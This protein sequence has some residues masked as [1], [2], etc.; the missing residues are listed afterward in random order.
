MRAK[1]GQ[2]CHKLVESWKLEWWVSVRELS[3]NEYKSHSIENGISAICNDG[4]CNLAVA[5]K[6]NLRRLSKCYSDKS[7]MQIS[8]SYNYL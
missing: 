3:A 6:G 8:E 5:S 7:S 2:C 4:I 1:D